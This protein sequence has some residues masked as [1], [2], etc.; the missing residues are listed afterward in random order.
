MKLVC[1][2]TKWKDLIPEKS[3]LE[4]FGSAC[5]WGGG[6]GGTSFAF[7]KVRSRKCVTNFGN[8]VCRQQTNRVCSGENRT[9][10]LMHDFCARS[11]IY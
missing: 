10:I 9:Y 3:K 1:V 4:N 8:V 2:G 5:V 11:P 6:K 7:R